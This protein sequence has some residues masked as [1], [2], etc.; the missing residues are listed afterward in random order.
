MLLKNVIK[1]MYKRLMPKPAQITDSVPWKMSQRKT[2][3]KWFWQW[4]KHPTIYF[5]SRFV[6]FSRSFRS[7]AYL[8]STIQ[9]NLQYIG[10]NFVVV[11]SYPLRFPLT[12][13]TDTKMTRVS[14]LSKSGAN[15]KTS[16]L[17]WENWHKFCQMTIFCKT[18]YFVVILNCSV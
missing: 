4:L 7:N 13:E 17:E 14:T 11:F 2:Y 16:I 1:S 18:L 3:I 9:P 10:S 12:R 15:C 5:L 8:S 6:N